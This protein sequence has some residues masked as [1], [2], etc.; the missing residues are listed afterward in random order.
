MRSLYYKPDFNILDGIRGVAAFYVVIN[1]ARGHM[2]QGG[3][4]LAA[5]KPVAEW[6]VFEKVYYAILQL[7]SIG[8]EFVIVFFVLSGFSIAYSL[9][10]GQRFGQFYLKRLIRL[11]PPFLLA[12]LWA[13]FAYILIDYFAPALNKDGYSVFTDFPIAVS[14]LLYLNKGNY[15]PQFWSLI[16]EVFF[17]LLIPLALLRRKFYYVFSFIL[18]ISGLLMPEEFV[19]R[20]VIT[21]F[22]FKYHF[23]FVVGVYLYFNYDTVKKY[24]LIK[25]ISLMYGVLTFL[26]LST[27]LINYLTKNDNITF[28]I[29]AITS[30]LMIV[31]FLE[32]GIS[33]RFIK[34]VGAMSYTLY[35]THFASIY[36]IYLLLVLMNMVSAEGKIT[37]WWIWPL[38]VISS[39][40]FAQLFYLVVE[41]NTKL[42]LNRLRSREK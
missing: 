20:S 4:E 16:H 9:R 35:I 28:F 33:N 23:Y 1:H 42:I 32:K 37:V 21:L 24:M 17:Y 18:F 29:S 19:M 6:S 25:H 40:F 8:T 31:N 2:L 7:T 22:L 11:Y 3:S 15:V 10:K 14:N 38:G 39:L 30:V 13:Y 5:V 27:V 34:W 26:F 36:L 41:K 12:L